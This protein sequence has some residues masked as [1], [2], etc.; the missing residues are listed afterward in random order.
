MG[1]VREALEKYAAG[2]NREFENVVIRR[3]KEEGM[4]AARFAK[5][6][7][8]GKAGLPIPADIGEIDCLGFLP[9]DE[10]LIIGECKMVK[11]SNEPATFR[12]DLDRFLGGKKNYVQQLHKKTDWVRRH[13]RQVLEALA[14]EQGFPD[15]ITASSLAPILITYYPTIASMFIDDYPCVSLPELMTA[16]R[17]QNK[18]PYSDFRISCE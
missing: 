17:Y 7:G 13:I 4:S 2:A 5:T 9:R 15:G 8:R 11:P 14:T 6:I 16:F 12:D 18:W 3:L 1:N 10:V